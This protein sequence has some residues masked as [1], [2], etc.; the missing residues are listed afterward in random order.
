MYQST[1][2]SPLGNDYECSGH[3]LY[4]TNAQCSIHY[5]WASIAAVRCPLHFL[6]ESIV[7]QVIGN[8]F[9]SSP[10]SKIPRGTRY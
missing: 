3:Y 7:L 8:Y 1:T 5:F 2:Y 6:W 10:V 9:L 4:V